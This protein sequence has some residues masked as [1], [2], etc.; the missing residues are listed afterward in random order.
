MELVRDVA[1]ALLIGGTREVGDEGDIELIRYD[2]LVKGA[3]VTVLSV[4]AGMVGRVTDAEM[5]GKETYV[6]PAGLVRLV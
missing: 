6:R 5:I 2:G 1:D 4:Y 3:A